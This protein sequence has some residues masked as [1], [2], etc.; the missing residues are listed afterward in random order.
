M[1]T[2]LVPREYV[3]ELR[4]HLYV[5]SATQ[6]VV[7]FTPEFKQ[8]AYDELHKGKTTREIFTE[9]GFDVEKLGSKR[10]ENFQTRLEKEAEREEGFADRRSGN[11]R[12]EAQTDETKLLKRL[13][14]LEH[15]VA[16]LQQENDFLKKIEEAEKAVKKN[17]RRK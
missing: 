10:L 4:E 2:R 11:H 14:Q 17:C 13:K 15:Q 6:R 12:Q 1:S 16:Y 7:T 5:K 8:Y 3:K 9:V